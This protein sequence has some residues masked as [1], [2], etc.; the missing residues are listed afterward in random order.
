MNFSQFQRRVDNSLPEQGKYL[1]NWSAFKGYY[2][3]H[4]EI[5][6]VLDGENESLIGAF[7]WRKTQQG[8]IYW[9]LRWYGTEKITEEDKDYMVFL[10]DTVPDREES[11]W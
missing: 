7:T 4:H 8:E 11:A 3:R 9:R 10:L 1:E 2:C 6:R 5:H